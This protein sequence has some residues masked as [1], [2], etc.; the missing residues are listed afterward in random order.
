MNTS[1][2]RKLERK[3][4][5]QLENNDWGPPKSDSYMAMACH[6]LRYKP[7]GDMTIEDVRM[8][9][10]QDIGLPYLMPIALDF[11]KENPLAEGMHY[12][13]D[14]LCAALRVQGDFFKNYPEYKPELLKLIDEVSIK[15][16]SMDVHDRDCLQ[17]AL[18]DAMRGFRT[19]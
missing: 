5:T 9:V 4:L 6:E 8:L 17:D 15:M 7:L 18:G 2:N 11:L 13:G 14:L 10:G 1:R 16:E 19:R 12:P 3:N